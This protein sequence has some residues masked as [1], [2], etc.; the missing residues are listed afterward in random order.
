MPQN[1]IFPVG[2]NENSISWLPLYRPVDA[3]AGFAEVYSL[4]TV[5]PYFNP[6]D[7]PFKGEF[8]ANAGLFT[9]ENNSETVAVLSEDFIT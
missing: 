1:A 2:E 7:N 4:N 3:A 8:G 9:F 5:A 6:G